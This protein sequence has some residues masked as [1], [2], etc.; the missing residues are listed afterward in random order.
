LRT[1]QTK[2]IQIQ[3]LSHLNFQNLIN[4]NF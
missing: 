2:K 1:H 4:F 3:N